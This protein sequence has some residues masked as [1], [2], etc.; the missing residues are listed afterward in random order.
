VDR[1]G[2]RVIFRG[3]KVLRMRSTRRCKRT[4]ACIPRRFRDTSPRSPNAASATRA[5]RLLHSQD[6]LPFCAGLGVASESGRSDCRGKTGVVVRFLVVDKCPK[7]QLPLVDFRG[8]GT[9]RFPSTPSYPSSG[10]LGLWVRPG[11][12][13]E[14]AQ[15][16]P[17]FVCCRR[18][19]EDLS[20]PP[21]CSRVLPPNSKS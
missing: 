13:L 8:P 17:S 11:G 1:L 19:G 5:C 10:L 20:G 3:E 4:M 12:E 9:S 7:R 2:G 16:A 18:F 14:I 6:L 15:P 21:P